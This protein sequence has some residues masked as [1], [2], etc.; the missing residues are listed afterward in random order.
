MLAALDKSS[1]LA[2]KVFTN[3]VLNQAPTGP[4]AFTNGG[5]V[6]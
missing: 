2:M 1:Y 6:A 4:S 3:Q 5:I